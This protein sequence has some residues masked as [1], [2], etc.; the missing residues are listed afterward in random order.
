MLL[1]RASPSS[2]FWSGSGGVLAYPHL[3]VI[4]YHLAA[5]ICQEVR[6]EV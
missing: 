3:H 5:V 2:L 6:A 4:S 1:L